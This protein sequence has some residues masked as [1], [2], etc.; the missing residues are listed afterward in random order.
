MEPWVWKWMGVQERRAE[1]TDGMDYQYEDE[2]TAG[3]ALHQ[4]LESKVSVPSSAGLWT[5]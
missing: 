3:E 2:L 4:V 1:V 5:E